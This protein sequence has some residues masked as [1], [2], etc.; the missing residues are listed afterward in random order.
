MKKKVYITRAIPDET[1]KDLASDF[2][3][4][5]NPED[6]ALTKAEFIAN[7]RGCDAVIC[8][9]TDI[10]D[11]EV[12]DAA[13]PT[14]KIFAN[15]AVGFNNFDLKSATARKI[16]LTNT[17]GVLDAA[18]ATHTFALLLAMAR[19][20]PEA[21]RYLREG[22]WEGWSPM[23]FVGAD[24]DKKTLGIA[25]LGRIGKSVARK[26]KAFDMNI[27]YHSTAP[28]AAIEAELGA[29]FVSK[30]G[31]LAQSDFL[32]LHVPLTADTK[33]FIGRSEL[34]QMKPSAILINVSRGPVVDEAALVD[35]LKSG[36]IA[37]AALDVYENEPQP[38][39]GLAGLPNTVL[40][41]H[42]A[43]ATV[44]TRADMGRIAASNVRKVLSGLKPDTCVNP[45]VL[46]V[47]DLG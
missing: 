36:V 2:D 31:L 1:V 37:G 13:A 43:S 16:V 8:L 41:P 25:G 39:P 46:Q 24:V 18:T 42:I 28:D 33:Y 12:L 6:R 15:Y 26:A 11:A 9:L 23:L 21:E 5:V 45:G 17:P 34:S 20:I 10:V 22:R 3:V 14:C 40:V 32:T 38:A 4:N 29:R 30:A 7:V 35:A 27:I 44:K 47:L 19:R